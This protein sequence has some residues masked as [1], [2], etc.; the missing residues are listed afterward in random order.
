MKRLNGKHI[1]LGISG[2]ISAYKTPEL[3]RC[4]RGHGAEVRVI[5]TVAAQK[6]ITKLS[7]QVV[8]GH[9]VVTNLTD[10]T[11]DMTINHIEL[12]E[13]ADFILLAPATANSLANLAMGFA[14]DLISTI[15]LVTLAPIAIA[16]A[17]NQRMYYAIATQ[18]NLNIIVKRGI[19]V[20]GPDYGNQACGNIG[21][22]RML[23]P[24]TLVNYVIQ[25]FHKYQQSLNNINVMLTAGPTREA[26]DP[27]RFLSNY[28]SGKMGF[29]IARAAVEKG[30]RV[31]LIS[32]PVNLA[33]PIGVERINVVSALEMQDAVMQ[34]IK[35]QHIFI[36]CAAVVDYRADYF[37]S[38]K[39]KKRSNKLTLK[40]VKNPD[41][42]T[43][44]GLLNKN[45]PYVVGFAAETHNITKFAQKKRINKHMD[46]ICANYISDI[47]QISNNDN[48]MLHLFWEHGNMILPTSTKSVLAHRLVDEI[49]NRYAEKNKH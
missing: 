41:I 47:Y 36:G 23:E 48:N 19:L 28:S 20:W 49:I 33:T 32:G 12:A 44:V 31:T 24:L 29:A 45:R 35:E 16:P 15:C 26:F 8:S 13:W 34:N 2:S 3:V 42:I 46:L 11:M 17:M 5:M 40:L 10:D 14:N 25:Y 38:K 30:G 43:N 18:T 22:G 7:L 4:L 21:L 6:F 1:I 27:I 39:I 9:P 37:S